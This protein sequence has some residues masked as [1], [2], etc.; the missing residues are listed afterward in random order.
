MSIK[1]VYPGI[2]SVNKI[3]TECT[4]K[5]CEEGLLIS[6]SSQSIISYKP[7]IKLVL[8]YSATSSRFL[9]I[10]RNAN[11]NFFYTEYCVLI[12]ISDA[13]LSVSE[14]STESTVYPQTL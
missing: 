3:S 9:I 10:F 13:T 7:S 1:I 6:Y 14:I 4:N 5:D 12:T 8:Y 11:Q 2:E